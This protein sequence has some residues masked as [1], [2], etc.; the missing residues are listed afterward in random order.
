MSGELNDAARADLSNISDLSVAHSR[1]AEASSRSLSARSANSARASSSSAS[2]SSPALRS[3]SQEATDAARADLSRIADLAA[4]SNANAERGTYTSTA[5]S[6]SAASLSSSSPAAGAGV[7]RTTAVATHSSALRSGSQSVEDTA[8]RRR[9]STPTTPVDTA[10]ARRF[11]SDQSRLASTLAADV[12][13]ISSDDDSNDESGFLEVMEVRRAPRIAI[14]LEDALSPPPLPGRPAEPIRSV[15]ASARRPVGISVDATNGEPVYSLR[16]GSSSAI[17]IDADGE[18]TFSVIRTDN[19]TTGAS[20]SAQPI[21]DQ[22]FKSTTLVR[23][24]TSPPRAKPPPIERPLLSTFTCPICFEPPA[25]ACLTPCGH[26]LCGECLFQTLKTQ[27]VQRGAMED[28]NAALSFGG[29]FAAFAPSGT[30]TTQD[31]GV[32]TRNGGTT[33]GFSGD[34]GGRGGS[35]R[36]R[37]KPDP[38]AGQCP[39]CRAKIKGG[40]SGRAKNGVLGLRLLVGKPVDDPREESSKLKAR[41]AMTSEAENSGRSTLIDSLDDLTGLPA[42]QADASTTSVLHTGSQGLKRPRESPPPS[43]S[44]LQRSESDSSS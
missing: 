2:A 28:E 4:F 9:S 42:D 40:F 18:P 38:L 24:T 41:E 1:S 16:S 36:P 17:V 25:N 3:R 30:F 6:R 29:M 43:P 5:R 27:A 39:V 35:A 7:V 8:S 19:S 31:V 14:A 33:A 13:E 20:R 15:R 44:N 34:R 22:R 10:E 21:T 11:Q 32:T 23:P 12:V 37:N 26:L